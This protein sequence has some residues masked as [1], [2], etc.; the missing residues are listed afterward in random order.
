MHGAS[1]CPSVG[2]WGIYSCLLSWPCSKEKRKKL[3]RFSK[4]NFQGWEIFKRFSIN[5]LSQ[6]TLVLDNSF[7]S[8]KENIKNDK[9]RSH[10]CRYFLFFIW[11]TFNQTFFSFFVLNFTHRLRHPHQT[12]RT[13]NLWL[14]RLGD[15]LRSTSHLSKQTNDVHSHS[16]E[17]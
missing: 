16:S 7:F 17:C 11:N 14:N 10:E 5:R 6:M 4:M 9:M 8:K 12:C 2:L 15:K 13:S 3:W 1:H